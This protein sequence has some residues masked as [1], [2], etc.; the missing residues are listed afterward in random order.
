MISKEILKKELDNFP[1]Y[2]TIDEVVGRL[3]VLEKRELQ[4]KYDGNL[5]NIS[6]EE[7]DTEMEKWFK[8]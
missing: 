7:L 8:M 5:G 1:D 4:M 2:M 6:V 3:I